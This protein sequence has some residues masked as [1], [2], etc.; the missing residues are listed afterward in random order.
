MSN[1]EYNHLSV[2]GGDVDIDSSSCRCWVRAT[3][4]S[5]VT[6]LAFG[7]SCLFVRFSWP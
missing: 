2:E 4:G 3:D 5:F 7:Y 6:F 1:Y